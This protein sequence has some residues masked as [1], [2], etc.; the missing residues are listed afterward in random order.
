MR[1]LEENALNEGADRPGRSTRF[2]ADALARL[3]A[4]IDRLAARAGLA[5]LWERIWPPV[6]WALTA[7]ALFLA[8]SWFGLWLLLPA[9]ARVAGVALFAAALLATLYPLTRLRAPRRAQKLARLDR[10]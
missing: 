4:Q 7:A 3:R 5:L 8:A 6:A 2:D 1:A 10:D 9:G